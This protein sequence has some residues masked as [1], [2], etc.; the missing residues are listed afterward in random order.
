M[1]VN[2]KARCWVATFQWLDAEPPTDSIIPTLPFRMAHAKFSRVNESVSIWFTFVNQV[3]A[4]TITN[5]LGYD[6]IVVRKVIADRELIPFQELPFDWE[7]V[8]TN[9]DEPVAGSLASQHSIAGPSV[10]QDSIGYDTEDA[11]S[12]GSVPSHAEF[13]CDFQRLER[14][15]KRIREL[16]EESG[17]IAKRLKNDSTFNFIM[18]H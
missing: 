2:T 18:D 4:S 6:H 11:K 12:N 9:H 13:I 7:S 8:R 17:T 1:E 16:D 14:I 3:R 5:A 10:R 15:L